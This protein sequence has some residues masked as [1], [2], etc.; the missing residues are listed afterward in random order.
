MI[1]LSRQCANESEYTPR[2]QYL[3]T[4][5]SA[6]LRHD[7]ARFAGFANYAVCGVPHL[8]PPAWVDPPAASCARF[9]G[10]PRAQPWRLVSKVCRRV[11]SLQL[12]VAQAQR[13]EAWGRDGEVLL[14]RCAP[15]GSQSFVIL[16]HHEFYVGNV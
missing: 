10:F 6:T 14:H 2:N 12:F 4:P 7:A 8:P 9:L 15:G 5:R 1:F 11:T 3:G 13:A 16:L